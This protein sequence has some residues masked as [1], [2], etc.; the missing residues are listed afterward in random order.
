MKRWLYI[1]HAAIQTRGLSTSRKA[2]GREDR[3]MIN[4]IGEKESYELLRKQSIGRLGCCEDGEPYVVPVNY[5]FDG[6]SIYIHSRPGHKVDVMRA[7][8]RVCL[9]ADEINDAY[10]WRSVIA[11]G[12]YEEINDSAQLDHILNEM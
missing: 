2:R 9:Q 7:N 3:K 4:E 11:F 6:K 12:W 1:D 5:W 8:P 10:N